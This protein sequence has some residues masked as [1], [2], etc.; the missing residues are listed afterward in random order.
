[1]QTQAFSFQPQE[2]WHVPRARNDLPEC[3][4]RRVVTDRDMVSPS[5]SEGRVGCQSSAFS[6]MEFS[7]CMRLLEADK[8]AVKVLLELPFRE[9]VTYALTDAQDISCTKISSFTKAV[10]YGPEKIISIQPP[11]LGRETA[12]GVLKRGSV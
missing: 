2:A 5:P 11:L 7:V 6:M 3:P 8:R 9:A 10:A 12:V 1:M 4:S